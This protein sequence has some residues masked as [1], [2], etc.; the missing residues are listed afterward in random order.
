MLKRSKFHCISLYFM[1]VFFSPNNFMLH[2]LSVHIIKHT[3][4]IL[5]F[6]RYAEFTSLYSHK[7]KNTH[8]TSYLLLFL[9]HLLALKSS[10]LIWSCLFLIFKKEKNR[11]YTWLYM[12]LYSLFTTILIPSLFLFLG[13]ILCLTGVHFVLIF[14]NKDLRT[15]TEVIKLALQ[16]AFLPRWGREGVHIVPWV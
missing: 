9:V 7:E 16:V 6:H 13:F 11:S 2:I 12:S 1:V 10:V 3:K 5:V 14:F 8:I 4:H 15:H